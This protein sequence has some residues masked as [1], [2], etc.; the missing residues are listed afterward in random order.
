MRCS[1][2]KCPNLVQ[3]LTPYEFLQLLTD[4]LYKE[5]YG[6]CLSEG[7][8][9]TGDNSDAVRKNL[10][11]SELC[12]V[13][14]EMMWIYLHSLTLSL[15]VVMRTICIILRDFIMKIRRMREDLF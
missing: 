5:R 11:T 13:H 3:Y 14:L 4:D 10:L 15:R 1:H 7:S 8:E 12:K 2:V 9:V 6:V